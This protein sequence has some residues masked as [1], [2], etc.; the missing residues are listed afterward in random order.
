MDGSEV[1][2]EEKNEDIGLN[3]EYIEGNKINAEKENKQLNTDIDGLDEW[4]G[5]KSENYIMKK[6]KN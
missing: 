1:L 4:C 6:Q 3:K 5:K 2:A